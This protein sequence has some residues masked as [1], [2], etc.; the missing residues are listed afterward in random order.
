M[1]YSS[2]KLNRG[3]CHKSLESHRFPTSRPLAG[4]II[5]VIL[6]LYREASAELQGHVRPSDSELAQYHPSLLI[7]GQHAHGFSFDLA[8]SNS[9]KNPASSLALVYI[10]LMSPSTCRV[11]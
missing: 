10:L 7:A 9:L 8:L 5:G 3:E 6:A 11:F 1:E 2:T 4:K